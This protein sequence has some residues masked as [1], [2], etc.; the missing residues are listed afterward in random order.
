[1]AQ[2]S[3]MRVQGKNITRDE[4]EGRACLGLKKKNLY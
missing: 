2:V 3:K 4:G 1:M